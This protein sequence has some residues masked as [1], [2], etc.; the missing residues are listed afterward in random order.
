MNAVEARVQEL[1][2]ERMASRPLAG[3]TK[4]AAE[5]RRWPEP[6]QALGQRFVQLNPA[7]RWGILSL[8]LD[9]HDAEAAVADAALL[10]GVQLPMPNL[11]TWRRG[12]NAQAHWL[13]RVPVGT[14][15]AHRQ[16]PQLY[17]RGV[18]QQLKAAYGADPACAGRVMRGLFHKDQTTR[19]Y[20][21]ELFDLRDLRAQLPA[22][23]VQAQLGSA[24]RGR[25]W[26]VF[27]ALSTWAAQ[28]V[29]AGDD[30][31]SA[32]FQAALLAEG[33]RLRAQ[34]PT[35]DHPYTLSELRRT[36][37][38]VQ[39]RTLRRVNAGYVRS[40]GLYVPQVE[41]AALRSRQRSWARSEPLPAEVAAA[42]M[43]AA[44]EIGNA[45]Q[46]ERAAAPIIEA[47]RRLADRGEP[48]TTRNVQTELMTVGLRISE[49][50]IT[51]HSAVWR[52]ITVGS[53]D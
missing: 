6:V 49:R 41:G 39:Q 22:A 52:N 4:A 1:L 45:K 9:E 26:Q 38:S 37:K 42:N 33:Q 7:H 43:A 16:E 19:F 12:G 21:P 50:T 18:Y 13:L 53:A 36:V 27:T 23:P 20:H 15:P 11:Q 51:K 5:R 44:R 29:A 3:H 31:N 47:A 17:A 46:Q 40:G 25:N 34:L 32:D 24:D 2:F 35:G 48:L 28:R 14:S 10:N 8:D 30:P